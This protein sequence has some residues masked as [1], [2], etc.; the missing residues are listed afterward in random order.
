MVYTG[1]LPIKMVILNS[2]SYILPTFTVVVSVR[3]VSV[4][5]ILRST[6]SCHFHL[7]FISFTRRTGTVPGYQGYRYSAVL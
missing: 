1:I 5:L 2:Y 6:F 3:S 7:L 4:F